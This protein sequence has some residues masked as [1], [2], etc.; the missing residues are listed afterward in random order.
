MLCVCTIFSL[1]CHWPTH[2]L[3]DS[4]VPAAYSWLSPFFG[5][6]TQIQ[7]L[8]VPSA[9]VL[10][11]SHT[12]RL[13]CSCWRQQEKF[14]GT[15]KR[16]DKDSWHPSH[17]QFGPFFSMVSSQAELSEWHNFT[18]VLLASKTTTWRS[19]R[20]VHLKIV[21]DPCIVPKPSNSSAHVQVQF[22]FQMR[23]LPEML[24]A[25]P[26]LSNLLVLHALSSI[27]SL[28][29]SQSQQDSWIGIV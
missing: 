12:T 21:H 29:A 5:L 7:E 24:A 27:S 2:P 14:I 18:S 9:I 20:S 11:K 3:V 28:L 26:E 13:Y 15:V 1:V 16:T 19:P 17:I 6:T 22:V 4:L 8:Q 23:W 10:K 25:V